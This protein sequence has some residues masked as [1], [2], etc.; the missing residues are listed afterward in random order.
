MGAAAYTA[1]TT[2][3]TAEITAAVAAGVVIWGALQVPKVGMRVYKMFFH[4]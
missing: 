1:M 4:G 2:S 3:L